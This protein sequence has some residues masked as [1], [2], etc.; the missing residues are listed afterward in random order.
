MRA[1]D[2]DNYKEAMDASFKVFAP[3]GISK[4][5]SLVHGFLIGVHEHVI[6]RHD[7]LFGVTPSL[8]WAVL[9]CESA[10]DGPL[11][12]WGLGFIECG[13]L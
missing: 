3:L 11:Q 2:E 10:Y 9:I 7:A 6:Y 5:T 13:G 8:L 4:Y 12:V 1:F